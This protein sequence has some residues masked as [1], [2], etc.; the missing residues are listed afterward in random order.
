[1]NINNL[2]IGVRLNSAF[3]LTTLILALFIGYTYFQIQNLGA[4]QNASA[5]RAKQAIYAGQARS[6]ASNLGNIIASAEINL[7]F[8]QTQTDWDAAKT[9]TTRDL[10]AITG[11]ANTAEEKAWVA[12]ANSAY[13]QIVSLFENKMLPALKAAN[14]S[15]P[16]TITMDAEM[17]KYITALQNPMFQYSVSLQAENIKGD[18]VFN[19]AQQNE[20][21][22]SLIVG[23]IGIIVSLVLGI[24]ISRSI[25]HPMA[26]LVQAAKGIAVGDLNQQLNIQSKDEIGS[27]AA[28]FGDMIDYLKAI[29]GVVN[30]MSRNDLTE[31]VTPKSNQDILGNAIKEMISNLR[32]T[33]QQLTDNATNLTTASSQLASS[34]SQAGQA[35]GQISTTIQQVAKGISQQ[36]ESISRTASSTEQM[37]RAIEGVARGAQDQAGSIT[38]AASITTEISNAIQKV[39]TG[40]QTSAQGASQA[41]E[42]ARSG[43]RI[44]EETIQGMQSIKTKVGL[45]AEKVA[46]MGRR[47]NEIGAIVETIDDIASQ[48]NLL[49][50]NAAIEAARA[51]EHGKGFAVVAD[52]VRKLAERSSTATKE[53]GNL[54]RG[55]Q[56]TISEAVSAMDEGAKEVENGVMRTN[57]S[58]QA[59]SSIMQAAETVKQQIEQIAGAAQAISNS[60][61]ELVSA[62]DSVSAVVEENTAAT[63]EM[64]ASSSEVNEAV[65]AIASVSEENSAA[66][67]EVSA[68]TEEM[69]AQVEEVTASAQYLSEMAKSLMKVVEQFRI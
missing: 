25:T 48:T 15:T 28:A 56:Q 49:A 67:E 13:D 14:A 65:E 27:L 3:S 7:N 42:T 16:E 47:S 29:A 24:S 12:E 62:M 61:N 5:T 59:L 6:D 30:K 58:E 54:I 43:A 22:V 17:D 9:M 41:A 55:I 19:D 35:T 68:S 26:K 50:L 1:M 21:V 39:S 32:T 37:G 45:S 23:I 66:V 4:L 18:Q 52:E 10:A 36:T 63:E 57:Q 40:A 60:S 31:S 38:K 51:G 33:I 20:I 8:Q 2:K 44:V 46:E 11:S 34:A 64:S 53:I 69:S